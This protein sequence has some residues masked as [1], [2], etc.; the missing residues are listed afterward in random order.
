MEED[1]KN[2][3][4]TEEIFL[5]YRYVKIPFKSHEKKPFSTLSTRTS[6]QKLESNQNENPE[7]FQ[8]TQNN[9]VNENNI[10]LENSNLLETNK[11]NEKNLKLAEEDDIIPLSIKI[12]YSLPSF[13]KMSCLVLLK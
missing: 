4:K 8:E 13:G 7:N 3:I 5:K 12:I 10:N 1:N 2:I 6:N 11:L 9:I